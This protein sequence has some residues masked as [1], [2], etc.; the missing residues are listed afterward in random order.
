M[1]QLERE[2]AGGVFWLGEE[3]AIFFRVRRTRRFFLG[4]AAR[5]FLRGERG[6][7]FFLGKQATR[8]S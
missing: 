4:A 1:R 5:V 8:V 3:A 2:G 7:R 6:E